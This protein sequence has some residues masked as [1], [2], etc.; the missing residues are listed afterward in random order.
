MKR[1]I[2][3]LIALGVLLIAVFGPAG[4]QGGNDPLF[5]PVEQ[6]V[7][8]VIAEYPHDATA[9]TQGLLYYNGS[10]YES[11]GKYGGSRLREVDMVNGTSVREISIPEEYFAEG[12]ARVDDTLIQLTYHAGTAFVY[13]LATFEQIGTFSY[14][15]EGWGLCYDGEYL[16][17]TNGSPFLTLRDPET[18]DVI[19]SG[20]VTAQ[21]QVVRQLNE[22]ECV[23]DYVYANVYQTDYIVKIDKHN[24]VV[25]AVIDLFE[26]VAPAERQSWEGADVLNGIV[27]LPDSDT[28]LVTGKW[29]PKM[30]EVRF[31]PKE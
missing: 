7:P 24:G 9:Y 1:S 13:D 28:F 22:L 14:E 30:Y 29:W 5:A 2:V 16:F 4:A 6:L 8:E 20:L 17:M 11:T 21:G 25:T 26:L 12:L 31:V 27:Y 3:G 23:G 19:F 18:F 15:G 10:L